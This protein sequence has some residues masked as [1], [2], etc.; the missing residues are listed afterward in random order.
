[1]HIQLGPVLKAM[2]LSGTKDPILKSQ[3]EKKIV[4]I[5]SMF[6]FPPE[7]QRE[8]AYSA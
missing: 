2:V 6:P 7:L 3:L 1:M 4:T 8:S 5:L